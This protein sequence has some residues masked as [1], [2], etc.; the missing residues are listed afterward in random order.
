[1]S[2]KEPT[3]Q[4]TVGWGN[5]HDDTCD[6]YKT[7]GRC[8]ND[9]FVA[10][11][12][13][14][15][16]RKGPGKD[17]EDCRPG[18][19]CALVFNDPGN[20]CCVCGK[21]ISTCVDLSEAQLAAANR[22]V[23]ANPRW[24][25]RRYPSSCSAVSATICTELLDAA[26]VFGGEPDSTP[27]S[28]Q[29]LMPAHPCPK[30]CN[31]CPN[32]DPV[33]GYERPK[34]CFDVVMVKGAE[35]S[36]THKSHNIMGKYKKVGT[37]QWGC[38]KM[39]D[40]DECRKPNPGQPEAAD[41]SERPIYVRDKSA[42]SADPVDSSDKYLFYSTNSGNWLI[43]PNYTEDLSWVVSTGSTKGLCP[44]SE[45]SWATWKQEEDSGSF[46]EDYTITVALA[47]GAP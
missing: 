22:I 24:N 46:V 31:V 15:G 8:A 30:A 27:Q 38:A 36:T 4:D 17:G 21:A 2:A 28:L 33:A 47:A 12:E 44:D 20:N 16:K 45:V 34:T 6:D 41:D 25:K 1:M 14:F 3:C 32:Y 11:Y 13:H 43:G 40:S 5:N 39:Q 19:D 10:G 26:F 23:D 35:A 37:M 29:L 18:Q 7:K 42:D 9:S